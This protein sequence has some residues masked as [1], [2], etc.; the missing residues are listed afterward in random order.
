MFKILRDQHP[1]LFGEWFRDQFPNP[2]NYY[3]ARSNFINTTATMS[4]MCYILGIGDRHCEN[5]LLD[6]ITGQLVLVDFNIIFHSGETLCVP[7][8][9]PFRLTHNMIDAMGVLGVDGPFRKCCEIILHIMQREKTTLL[10]Y[11]RPF[12]YDQPFGSE[13]ERID[14]N[15]LK[16]ITAIKSKL[17]GY[18]RKFQAT[19]EIALST[20]GQVAYLINE[21]TNEW[22]QAMMYEHWS[23]FF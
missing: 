14:R 6:T 17:M 9:V 20:E 10:S 13:T 7:E 5:V 1:P 21:A 3:Q 19:T 8:T 4:I 2:H 15:A 16:Q 18:V 23:A 12:V 11:L 22:N